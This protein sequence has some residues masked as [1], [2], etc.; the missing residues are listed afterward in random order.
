M[1]SRRVV[2]AG[3]VIWLVA[4]CLGGC[5]QMTVAWTDLD[6]RGP[7]AAPAL[8]GE[9][10]G[11]AP[12][13]D[14]AEWESRRRPALA[15]ALQSSVYGTMPDASRTTILDRRVINEN[16]F[17]GRGRLEE[18]RIG[19]SATFGERSVDVRPA[20][21]GAAGFIMN[22]VTPKNV[23]GPAPVII[24]ETFCQRWDTLPDAAVA[25]PNAA[26]GQRNEG[27]MFNVMTYVFGRYICTPPVEA[28]L[29]AGYAIAT[30]HPA[31]IVP[32]AREAGVAELRR[33]SAGWADD[34]T[35]WGAVA[36]WA[37]VFSRVVDA[38]DE[39]PRFAA[40]AKIAWGHSR[41]GKAALLAAASDARIDGAIAH[42]SGTGGAS[43]NVR[44]KGES[45]EAITREYPHWFAP[46]YASF[47]GREEE[48]GV[49][50]HALLGLIA[51]RPVL[52]GNARRDVWSDP[53]GA[54]RAAVGAT[55]A[56]ALYGSDGLRQ[57]D[58][59]AFNPEADLS[60][61]I[62]PG[63]HGV[64]EEDWPAFIA[65]LNAHFGNGRS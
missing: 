43:L 51:P 30:I 54:F 8:L 49:D 15:R 2:L 31:D 55:P 23:T 29:D 60:F 53:N 59:R 47:A 11:D 64:V 14:A 44:K 3:A 9:F 36:A 5:V 21:D 37:W 20:F 46:A 16:A 32:D 63:T 50:Q 35:R 26:R 24:M 27:F 22:L 19:A 7:E 17:G 58:L 38:L 57:Q 6:P 40:S 62:R 65:F 25:R 18:Y 56:Y 12:V 39:D 4:L 1:S 28:I 52:L 42:Q 10:E 34:E 33:L 41:Y 48:M 13:T 61:W 45:V